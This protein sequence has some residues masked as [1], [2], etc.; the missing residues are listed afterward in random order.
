MKGYDVIIAGA[1]I[2]G[3]TAALA[4]AQRGYRIALFDGGSVPHPLASSTDI[5]KVVRL[6]YGADEMY[7][8]LAERARAGWLRWNETWDEPLYHEVGLT[9]LTRGETMPGSFTYESY[10]LLQAHGHPVERLTRDDITR[11]FPAWNADRYQDGY[12]N[13]RGGYVESGRVVAA[14]AAQAMA[15]G[16]TLHENEAVGALLGSNGRVEGIATDHGEDYYCPWVLL[17]TGAWT[18]AFLPELSSVMRAVGQP[19]FHLRPSDPAR[20]RPPHFYVF[21]ADVAHTGWYGFPLHPREGV[22]KIAHHGPG[23]PLHPVRGE[24]RVSADQIA[25]LRSFLAD[26]LPPLADAPLVHTR[27]CLYCDVRDGHFWLDRHPQRQ[28]LVVAAGGSGHGFKFAP[29][30]GELIADALEGKENPF[31]ARFAWRTPDEDSVNEEAT[32]Y[33]GEGDG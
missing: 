3:L 29:V 21:S 20:F 19:V 7:M 6:E 33:L 1:G 24:R 22:V 28:G 14:L 4:L 26:A 15:A 17:T 8:T 31:R 5:S 11:R 16:I 2:F 18:P 30:L 13:P 9:M 27:I 12:F 32:R 25:A 23:H 10:R